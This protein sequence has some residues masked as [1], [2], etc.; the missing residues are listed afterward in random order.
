MDKSV[1]RKNVTP[2]KDGA[3]KQGSTCYLYAAP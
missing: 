3:Q 2:L 1:I